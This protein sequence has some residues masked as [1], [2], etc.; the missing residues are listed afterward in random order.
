MKNNKLYRALL[1]KD[2]DRQYLA[3][4]L[5]RH[6]QYISERLNFKSPWTQDEMYKIMDYLNEDYS[7]IPEYFPRTDGEEMR[8]HGK[9]GVP[10]EIIKAIMESAVEKLSS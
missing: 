6:P 3:K 5:N 8:P 2:I 1:V 9:S 10:V 7:R 4:L